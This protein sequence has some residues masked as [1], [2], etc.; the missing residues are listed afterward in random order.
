MVKRISKRAKAAL[1]AQLDALPVDK[2]GYTHP[3]LGQPHICG[4]EGHGFA[5]P[6]CEAVRESRGEA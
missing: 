2:D 3:P 4:M 5:C 6:A 1:Q